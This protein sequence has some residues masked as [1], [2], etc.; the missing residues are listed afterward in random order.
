V[1]RIERAFCEAEGPL[2][3]GFTVAGD[4]DHDASIRIAETVLDAGADILEL[5]VPFSDPVADGPVIQ[6]ADL[7]ALQAGARTAAVFGMVHEIRRVSDRPI[8]LLTYYN[9]VYRRGLSRFYGEAA[10]A[11][12]DGVLIVDLPL[13][14]A[15]EARE[16]ARR[17][18]IDQILLAAP[19]TGDARLARIVDSASGFLYLVSRTGVTGAR[20]DLPGDIRGLIGRVKERSSIPVAV[21]FGISRPGHVRACASAGA[22]GVIVGSAIVSLVEKHLHDPPAMREAIHTYV[23]QM[24]DAARAERT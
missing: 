24:K 7:R 23:R 22:D 4:P 21:G 17:A 20:E 5:G 8:V 11:G 1:S 10:A 14:E 13:E 19:T 6:R 18:G 3:I 2:F 9:P 12:A 16:C 15:D